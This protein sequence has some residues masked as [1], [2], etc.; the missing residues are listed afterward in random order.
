MRDPGKATNVFDELF[1]R[2][3]ATNLKIRA[4]LMDQLIEYVD[5]HGLTQGEAA[6]AFN[7]AQPRISYLVNGKISKFSIDALVNMC[8]AAGI[9]V[10]V[11]IDGAR[12]GHDV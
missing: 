12:A 11:S 2:D 9:D 5:E 10:D 1:N 7:A 6:E 8:S 3:E 4:K